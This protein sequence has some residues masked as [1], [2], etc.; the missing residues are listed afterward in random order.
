MKQ[1]LS[2]LLLLPLLTGCATLERLDS[3]RSSAEKLME[4]S[5]ESA[6]MGTAP[7]DGSLLTK[8]EAE[9]IALENAGLNRGQIS[10]LRTEYEWD[11]GHHRYEVDFR[12]GPWEHHYEIDARTGEIL[13][14]EREQDR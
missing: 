2:L 9:R 13:S 3:V 10:R 6:A 1:I 11:D 8:T 5:V 4:D 14:R 7:T 12:Q